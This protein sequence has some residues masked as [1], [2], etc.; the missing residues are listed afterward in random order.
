MD[1][2]GSIGE[3]LEK[4]CCIYF[5]LLRNKD[6]GYFIKGIKRFNTSTQDITFKFIFLGNQIYFIF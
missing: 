4:H 1:L 5:N 2:N 6:V 3:S